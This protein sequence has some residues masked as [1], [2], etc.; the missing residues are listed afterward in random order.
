VKQTKKYLVSLRT[1]HV[2]RRAS[3]PLVGGAEVEAEVVE[4]QLHEMHD[5]PVVV[6]AAAMA[7]VVVME[8]DTEVVSTPL[9]AFVD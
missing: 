5:K 4:A 2:S 7:E 6:S 8:A 3:G 9:L 1:S